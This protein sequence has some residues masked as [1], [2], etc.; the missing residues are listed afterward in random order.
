MLANTISWLVETD[1][2]TWLENEPEGYEFGYCMFDELPPLAISILK[3]K[4][5]EDDDANHDDHSPQGQA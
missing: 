5:D 4:N 2:S 3:I 1:P